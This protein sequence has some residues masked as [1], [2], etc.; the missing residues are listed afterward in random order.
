MAARR[1]VAVLLVLLFLSS[2]ATA[3]APVEPGMQTST[4]SSTAPASPGS[5]AQGAL[6]RQ[7]VDTSA[8][9]PPV[10]EATPGD[11]L[12]LRITSRAPGTIELAGIGPTEDVGPDQPALFDVLLEGAGEFPVRF[13]GSERRV[14]TIEVSG[15]G[16]VVPVAPAP[17][18]APDAGKEI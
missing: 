10:I 14:A 16:P 7:S 4:S 17:A 15:P 12:Q 18:P 6:I 8:A 5:N 3:L 1:L 11:Q 13:L 2:L 9:T